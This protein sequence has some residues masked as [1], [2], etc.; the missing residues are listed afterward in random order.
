MI[1]YFLAYPLLLR[2]T[3]R[4]SASERPLSRA[5]VDNF[6]SLFSLPHA[7]HNNPFKARVVSPLSFFYILSF[8][9]LVLHFRKTLSDVMRN[10]Y[11]LSSNPFLSFSLSTNTLLNPHH[12]HSQ[13]CLYNTDLIGRA[14]VYETALP[15]VVDES[16]RR[17]ST[18]ISYTYGRDLCGQ[19]VAFKLSMTGTAD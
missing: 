11:V 13:G 18:L 6:L 3:E 8:T 17:A 4:T 5:V 1:C 16:S 19:I 9:S 12:R 10:P 15:L 2:G 14:H 7:R